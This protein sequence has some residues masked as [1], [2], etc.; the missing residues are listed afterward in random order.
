MTISKR[1]LIVG[2]ISYKPTKM[3]IDQFHKLAKGLMRLGHDVQRFGYRNIMMRC[4]PLPSKRIARSFAKKSRLAKYRFLIAFKYDF[5]SISYLR[6]FFRSSAL[7][8]K[9][10]TK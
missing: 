6:M 4:S 8:T 3:F 9:L 7:G 5:A 2:D 10:L 1:V